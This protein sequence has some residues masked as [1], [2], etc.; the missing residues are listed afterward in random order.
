MGGFQEGWETHLKAGIARLGEDTD[1]ALVV[2]D[3]YPVGDVEAEPRAFADVFRRVER[4]EDPIFH[5]ARDAGPVVFDL[6][7][8]PAVLSGGTDRD[9]AVALDGVYGVVEE[10]RPHLV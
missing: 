3:H 9:P 8:H 1:V 4:L 7:Q 6:D 5:L 2:L 10:V